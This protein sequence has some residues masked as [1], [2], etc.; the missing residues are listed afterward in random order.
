MLKKNRF[1]KNESKISRAKSLFFGGRLSAASVAKNFAVV[2][3][4]L[5]IQNNLPE[6]LV[7]SWSSASRPATA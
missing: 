7:L 5:D 1:E 2:S 4:A 3:T 6:S